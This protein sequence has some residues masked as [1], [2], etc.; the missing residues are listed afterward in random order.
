[1]TA[2]P[3]VPRSATYNPISHRR[4]LVA[5][6]GAPSPSLSFR[7]R[8]ASS[9]SSLFA[10]SH[11][12]ND[13]SPDPSVL[14]YTEADSRFKRSR[15]AALLSPSAAPSRPA[16]TAS[17]ELAARLATF[18][19]GAQA[20]RPDIAR[21]RRKTECTTGL[22][23]TML[24]TSMAMGFEPECTLFPGHL[25]AQALEVG[26]A[27]LAKQKKLHPINCIRIRYAVIRD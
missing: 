15:R 4:H 19:K 13:E 1:M 8:Q 11:P 10:L 22:Q 27:S 9:L 20:V 16:I 6:P 7:A 3:T 25:R 23:N 24:D 21:W 14:A 17:G 5:V 18:P 12:S 2:R 26:A